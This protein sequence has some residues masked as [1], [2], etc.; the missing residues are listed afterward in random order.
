MKPVPH[1]DCLGKL[2]R[3]NTAFE[4]NTIALRF[5][6]TP[7]GVIVTFEACVS[8]VDKLKFCLDIIRQRVYN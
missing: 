6:T 4:D 1:D 5:Q 7:C 2:A 8:F 3:M